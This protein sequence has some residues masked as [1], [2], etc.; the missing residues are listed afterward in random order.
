LKPGRPKNHPNQR[1]KNVGA[2]KNRREGARVQKLFSWFQQARWLVE[3]KTK[4]FGKVIHTYL[5]FVEKRR[6]FFLSVANGA[7]MSDNRVRC[8]EGTRFLA[9]TLPAKS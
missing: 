3:D 9:R 8:E 1:K 2:K 4:K 7:S 5:R 6:V